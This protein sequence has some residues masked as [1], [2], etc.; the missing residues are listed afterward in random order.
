MDGARE[1]LVQT[2]A[3][4]ARLRHLAWIE[5]NRKRVDEV[6]GGKVGYVFVPDTGRRG[7]N[8]LV[9]QFR[10]Q[11]NKPGMVID[12]RFNNGGQIPDRFVEMLSRA[13]INYWGVRDGNDW[14][15]PQMS[16]N[17]AMAM[18]INGWSGSGG[19]CFPFYF[20]EARLGPLIGTRT[21]GGLIGM[22]GVPSL[23]DGGSVSVPTFGIYSRKGDWIIEG[24]GVDPDVEVIDDPSVM[25]RGKDPQLERAIEYVMAEL[26]KSPPSDP[27][28]PK[29]PLRAGR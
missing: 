24:Y 19:D 14:Q 20:R 8:E 5:S 10:A 29:Y 7:Q 9:R 22:T 4:E 28:K 2:L 18:L 17:G 6:S 1:V 13:P 21:W 11:F 3:D 23:I 27:R 16:H 12:E 25:A 26:K 15:W